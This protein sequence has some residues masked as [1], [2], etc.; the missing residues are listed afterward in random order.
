MSMLTEEGKRRIER[1]FELD[2]RAWELLELVNAEWKSDPKSV[3]CFD[4]R[5]VKEV[6]TII[7]EKKTLS[8]W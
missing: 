8:P 7:K 1:S 2:K 4:L 5:I 6:A 3:Q